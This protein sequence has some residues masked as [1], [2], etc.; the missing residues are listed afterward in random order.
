MQAAGGAKRPPV[1]LTQDEAA[2][3]RQRAS[4]AARGGNIASGSAGA[5]TM[6]CVAAGGCDACLG[7][8]AAHQFLW[9]DAQM[10]S[11]CLIAEW[12]RASQQSL[13]SRV[14]GKVE[15]PDDFFATT[16]GQLRDF[17][18]AVHAL[19]PTDYSY[20]QLYGVRTCLAERIRN[21][22][23]DRSL[24]T[25]HVHPLLASLMQAVTNLVMAKRGNELYDVVVAEVDTHVGDLLQAELAKAGTQVGAVACMRAMS[26]W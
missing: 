15:L 26:I 19:R 12:P 24:T 11:S 20:E 18:Q 2:A 13:H 16:W 14:A 10:C 6:A 23:D 9:Y 3:K 7:G 21:T 4:E 1:R 17:I 5:A 22:R 25:W 8:A